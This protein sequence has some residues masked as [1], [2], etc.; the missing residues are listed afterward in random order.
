MEDGLAAAEL[1]GSV[2]KKKKRPEDEDAI[3]GEKHLTARYAMAAVIAYWRSN[4]GSAFGLKYWETWMA[5]Q[6]EQL[7]VADVIEL[8]QAFRE[9]RT[10]H[11]DHM[12]SML[13]DVFKQ[14]M[15]DKWHDEVDFHQR[16]LLTLMQELEH[17][18]YYDEQ[19][20]QAC[21]DTIGHKKRINNLTFFG[22]FHDVMLRFNADPKSPFFQKLDDAIKH[23][24]DK[25]Y[26]TNREWR[27]D[28]H[29]GRLRSLQELID[30]REE[31]KIDD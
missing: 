14:V 12:R 16:R 7:H 24:K 9:N 28:F 21:F 11:R 15:L 19:I 23:L 31:A 2:V 3:R 6:A 4:C 1:P 30:R 25:H 10:H 20:W 5:S 18:N 26:T 17:L 29:E 8:C 22:Y 13:T 27:Y